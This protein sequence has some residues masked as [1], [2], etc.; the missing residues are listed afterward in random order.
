M[1]AAKIDVAGLVL[2]GGKSSRMGRDKA[3][4]HFEGRSLLDRAV[5]TLSEACDQVFISSSDHLHD[6]PSAQRI[7][8][9]VKA[10]GP[11]AGLVSGL[12]AIDCRWLLLLPV[13]MPLAT[14]TALR[15][16]LNQ[17]KEVFEAIVFEDAG[18]LQGQM[19]LYHRRSLELAERQLAGADLSLKAFLNK[20]KLQ[21]VAAGA[22]PWYRSDI[23]QN[24]NSAAD[25]KRFTES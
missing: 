11:L 1:G 5:N 2:A 24:I 22:C 15:S 12:K 8:D 7:P 19:G 9:L 16:L 23:F 10:A 3:S 4:L 20:L 13:D 17:R 18:H 25:W 6:R 14:S 21:I